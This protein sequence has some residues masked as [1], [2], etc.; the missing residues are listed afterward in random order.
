MIIITGL[1]RRENNDHFSGR[2]RDVISISRLW[3]PFGRNKCSGVEIDLASIRGIARG[4]LPIFLT[5]ENMWKV[6]RVSVLING[7]DE[8][9]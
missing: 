3:I 7:N 9:L 5:L 4:S 1:I 8:L 6:A 2:N